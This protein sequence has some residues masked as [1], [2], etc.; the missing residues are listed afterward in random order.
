VGEQAQRAVQIKANLR[1]RNIDGTQI[2]TKQDR[3]PDDAT[4]VAKWTWGAGLAAL[5][6]NQ[7]PV[8]LPLSIR[9]QA[10]GPL[11]IGLP[12]LSCASEITDTLGREEHMARGTSRRRTRAHIAMARDR[13]WKKQSRQLNSGS[14]G[15]HSQIVCE[16]QCEL[17]SDLLFGFRGLNEATD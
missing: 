9:E 14:S 10:D 3:A 7:L 2:I 1:E 4:G 6:R 15:F 11:T 12:G 5:H 17:Y 16:P 8:S 13:S